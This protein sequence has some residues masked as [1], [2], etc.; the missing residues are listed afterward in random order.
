MVAW[1]HECNGHEF[2]QTPGDGEEQGSLPCCNS[3]GHEELDTT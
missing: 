3:W 2:G 1:H